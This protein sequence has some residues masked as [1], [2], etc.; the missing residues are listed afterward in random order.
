MRRGSWWWPPR[1]SAHRVRQDD[2]RLLAPDAG[3]RGALKR[4]LEVFDE[5]GINLV[6]HRIAPERRQPGST[7]FSSTSR[8]TAGA[9]VAA[10]IEKL[11]ARCDIVKVLGQL[12]RSR[13]D[14]AGATYLMRSRRPR[15]DTRP[16]IPL[17]WAGLSV[18]G[19][20]FKVELEGVWMAIVS[21]PSVGSTFARNA[22]QEGT[23]RCL[24]QF[25]PGLHGPAPKR[26]RRS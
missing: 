14:S 23:R 17:A 1:R 6:A 16:T 11:Q 25:R 13:R 18:R 7:S 19:R 8:V 15:R 4:A 12:P 21:W 20:R 26:A 24:V 2:A 3:A 5:E 9:P 22:Q 10:V